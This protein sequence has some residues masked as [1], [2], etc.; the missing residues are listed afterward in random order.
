MW[1]PSGRQLLFEV[2]G[3]YQP[4]LTRASDLRRA[5][6]G[7]LISTVLLLAALLTP[8]GWRL[9]ADWRSASRSADGAAVAGVDAS[10]EEPPHCREPA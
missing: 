8:L 7:L 5:L 1:T 6:A 9:I 10:D 4:V 3:D 2:Y